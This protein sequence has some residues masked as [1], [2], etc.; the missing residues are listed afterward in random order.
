MTPVL[1]YGSTTWRTT[2]QV[3]QPRPYA[4]SLSMGGTVSNTSRVI[5]VMKGN[6]MM[7]RIR[8]AVSMP[9]PYGGPANRLDRPGTSSNA[10]LRVG[11][12]Y[13]CSSGAVTN[14]PQTPYMILGM[15]ATK[16]NTVPTSWI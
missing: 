5:E 3:V 1:V 12:T 14:R 7:L 15:H 10:L 2:S 4:D 13:F 11:C 6:T 9:M 8:P 16:P